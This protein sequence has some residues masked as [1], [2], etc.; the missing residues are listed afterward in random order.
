[1]LKYYILSVIGTLVLFLI[2]VPLYAVSPWLISYTEGVFWIL[3]PIIAWYFNKYMYEKDIDNKTRNNLKFIVVTFVCAILDM[4][5]CCMF[6]GDPSIFLIGVFLYAVAILLP[7]S[8][9][10]GLSGYLCKIR[11]K[12]KKTYNDMSALWLQPFTAVCVL[13]ITV[14]LYLVL[15]LDRFDDYYEIENIIFAILPFIGLAHGL[16]SIRKRSATC[17]LLY[18]LVSLPVNY[19]FLFAYS[20]LSYPIMINCTSTLGYDTRYNVFLESDHGVSLLAPLIQSSIV[21][22]PLLT[23]VAI[24]L[25]LTVVKRKRVSMNERRDG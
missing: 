4:T 12:N 23:A 11:S 13:A 21:C 24:D 6:Y 15:L 10:M 14:A 22:I 20:A 25:I 5:Y 8:L 2:G 7:T 3:N 19:A 9:S 17:S 16:Y 18:C 1:M